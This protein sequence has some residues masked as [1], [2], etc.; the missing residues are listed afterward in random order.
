[1]LSCKSANPDKFE[2][3]SVPLTILNG[4]A[5]TAIDDIL[6]ACQNDLLINYLS[7]SLTWEEEQLDMGSHTRQML[8]QNKSMAYRDV[9]QPRE[10]SQ[11]IIV[12]T[13]ECSGQFVL[14]AYQ[15]M[16]I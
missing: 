2:N 8:L 16:E 3:D 9:Q 10:Q 6:K 5:A 11:R 12:G 1:M 4:I 14:Q 7:D 15:K 13:G